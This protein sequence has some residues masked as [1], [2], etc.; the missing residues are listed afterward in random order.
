MSGD[1]LPHGTADGVP[2]NVRPHTP[3]QA[4]LRVITLSAAKPGRP[5]VGMRGCRQRCVAVGVVG[6]LC[7]YQSVLVRIEA[8]PIL[9]LT[10]CLQVG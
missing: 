3:W 2:F 6:V 1:A 7:N 9:S 5:L 10:G 8:A 4:G